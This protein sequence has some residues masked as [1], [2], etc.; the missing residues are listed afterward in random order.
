MM[1]LYVMKNNM[2]S[3][4]T[5]L[6]HLNDKTGNIINNLWINIVLKLFYDKNHTHK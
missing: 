6:S 1:K 5:T 3:V 4:I 2:I